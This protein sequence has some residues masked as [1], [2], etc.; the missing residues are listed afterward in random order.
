MAQSFSKPP[1]E[2]P[3]HGYRR[4]LFLG[5][6]QPKVF[7]GKSQP[8]FRGIPGNKIGEYQNQT[9]RG[10]FGKDFFK[11]P[12]WDPPPW[13]QKGNFFWEIFTLIFFGKLQPKFRGIPGNKLG[14]FKTKR[15]GGSM[16]MICENPLMRLPPWNQRGN[17]FW[18]I[19]TLIFSWGNHDQ[20]LE[21]SL[22]IYLG[23][24]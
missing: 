10:I 18:E 2:T 11:P 19:F 15:S 4:G 17:V 9:F 16:G 24:L 7:L 8:S 1:N 13:I 3:L 21:G 23:N 22:R 5:S 20:S 12:W 6:F 14:N